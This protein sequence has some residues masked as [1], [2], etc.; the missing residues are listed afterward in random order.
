MSKTASNK[1]NAAIFLKF[2]ISDII[3]INAMKAYVLAIFHSGRKH[4][5]NTA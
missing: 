4:P 5:L 2:K 1:E 3:Q